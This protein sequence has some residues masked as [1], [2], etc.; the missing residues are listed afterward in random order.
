MTLAASCPGK[1][2]HADQIAS[3]CVAE[4]FLYIM[5]LCSYIIMIMS[6]FVCQLLALYRNS[7]NYTNA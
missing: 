5:L 3:A 2:G 1:V 4:T 7:T 6:G